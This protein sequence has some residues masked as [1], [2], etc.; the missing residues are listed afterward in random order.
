MKNR[1]KLI[2]SLIALGAFGMVL[3][4]GCADNRSSIF[5]IGAL[6]VPVDTCEVTPDEGAALLLEPKLDTAISPVYKVPIL[7]ANQLVSRGN[8]ATLRTE[9]S[10][11]VLREAIVRL[12]DTQGADIPNGTFSDPIF[13]TIDPA[14]GID[15]S[16]SA[17]LITLIDGQIGPQ[18]APGKYIA[19]VIIRGETLGNIEVETD[20]WALP[21]DVCNGCLVVFVP[22]GDDPARPGVDCDIRDEAAFNCRMG[23]DAPVD[24]RACAAINPAVCAP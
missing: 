7:V 14:N 19:N 23:M 21:I 13:G 8:T 9:T 6:L 1:Q 22:E 3:G 20:E 10:R 12:T 5:T 2:G 11:V 24:C 18:L 17:P 15:P 16:F 4:P